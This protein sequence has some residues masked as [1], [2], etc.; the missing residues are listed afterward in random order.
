[1]GLGD[2][3]YFILGCY[4]VSTILVQ[5]KLFKP[6]RELMVKKVKPLGTLFNCMMCTSFWVGLLFSTLLEFSPSKELYEIFISGNVPNYLTIVTHKLFD[7]AFISGVVYH[8]YIIEL[9]I[10]SKLPNEQ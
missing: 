5:S 8:I 4:G 10:E 2:I 3:I 1:M 9:L 6:F 7:A